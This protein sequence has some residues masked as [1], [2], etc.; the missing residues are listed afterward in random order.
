MHHQYNLVCLIL[1][2]SKKSITKII[3]IKAIPTNPI[4][5][6]KIMAPSKTNPSEIKVSKYAPVILIE[7]DEEAFPAPTPNKKNNGSLRAI[8]I[9]FQ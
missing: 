8:F 1:I 2:A 9:V 6:I 4:S 7:K 3:N 5:H